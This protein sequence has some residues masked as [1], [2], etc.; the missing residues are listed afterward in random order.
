MRRSS[1]EGKR[2]AGQESWSRLFSRANV[3]PDLPLH[4]CAAEIREAMQRHSV[5]I[6][7]GETGSGKTT[8]VPKCALHAGLGKEGKI[9]LTQPRRLAAVR[10]A[11]RIAE[12]CGVELG[13]EIGYRIRFNAK[14]SASVCLEVV[15][16][17]IPVGGDLRRSPFRECSAVIVDEVHERSVNMDVILGLLKKER[18]IRP[19]LRIV[20]MSATLQT[21]TF[22]EFFPDA[23]L[24]RVPGRTYPVEMIYDPPRDEDAPLA[25]LMAD[26]VRRHVADSGAGNTLCFLPTERSI[27]E[28]AGLLTGSFGLGRKINVF[29]LYSR[30]A[31]HEQQRVF[32]QGGPRR[33]ILAT[34]IAETSLTLPGVTRVIDSGWVRMLRYQPTRRVSRLHLEMISKASANQR[35]GRAGRTAPGTCVRLYSRDTFD[36]MED[37][38]TP[39][40]RRIDL[41]GVLLKLIDHGMSHPEVFPFP[42]APKEKMFREGFGLLELL[43]LIQEEGF[44]YRSTREGRQV[45]ALPLSPRLGHFLY[46]SRLEG[47]GDAAA[48]LAAYLSIQ[49]PKVTPTGEEDAARKAHRAWQSESSDFAGIVKIYAKWKKLCREETGKK[50]REWTKKQYLSLRRMNEWVQLADELAGVEAYAGGD[51]KLD[52]GHLHSLILGSHLDMLAE[53]DTEKKLYRSPDSGEIFVHPASSLKDNPPKWAVAAEL[54]DTGRLYLLSGAGIE[55]EWLLERARDNLEFKRRQPYYDEKTRRVVS[56]EE[57]FLRGRLVMTRTRRD[58]FAVDPEQATAV[59]FRE[60]ILDQ[61]LESREAGELRSAIDILHNMDAAARQPGRFF[62]DIRVIRVLRER[63]GLCSSGDTLAK[64][65]YVCPSIEDMLESEERDE[66][67]TRFPCMVKVGDASFEIRYRM[68]VKGRGDGACLVVGG[69][70]ALLLSPGD[71]DRAVPGYL[72]KRMGA[73]FDALSSRVRR[74]LD[75]EQCVA[76]WLDEYQQ[77]WG[78]EDFVE[79]WCNRNLGGEWDGRTFRN[80]LAKACPDYLIPWIDTG[81]GPVRF[82]R[83]LRRE[84]IR[85]ELPKL[86]KGDAL[87]EVDFRDIRSLLDAAETA[88]EEVVIESV[89]GEPY[90]V[91]SGLQWVGDGIV[92][93]FFLDGKTATRETGIA[94]GNFATR[95]EAFRF[96]LSEDSR[97][98]LKTLGIDAADYSRE[99][100]SA[101][102]REAW[103][104]LGKTDVRRSVGEFRE[105]LAEMEARSLRE[106]APGLFSVAVRV[107]SAGNRIRLV[108]ASSSPAAKSIDRLCVRWTGG[109]RPRPQ[110]ILREGTDRFLAKLGILEIL[111]EAFLGSRSEFDK[112]FSMFERAR[113]TLDKLSEIEF[114]RAAEELN[115]FWGKLLVSPAGKD[116]LNDLAN[117]MLENLRSAEQSINSFREEFGDCERLFFGWLR[118]RHEP[119]EGS[120][121]LPKGLELAESSFTPRYRR[122]ESCLEFVRWVRSN[123]RAGTRR[124]AKAGKVEERVSKGKVAES[125]ATA[126]KAGRR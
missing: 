38:T 58:H 46:H 19:D 124:A 16:D 26:A 32:R 47:A 69:G 51:F 98:A 12:E 13:I 92:R 83:N 40:I 20:L 122:V 36:S 99:V 41:A 119:G 55:P 73:C 23:R 113:I 91:W 87:K 111:S 86:L 75:R 100:K 33:V 43:G 101:C 3:N 105:R 7:A 116:N 123:D 8:Q 74:E 34:N 85:E 28:C 27:K 71:L 96:K 4:G 97:N 59:F 90:S 81:E 106:L 53:Y 95:N 37:Y 77:P 78:L 49:D 62:N 118:A 126:W 48:V 120:A 39:E 65:N 31:Q 60:A 21:D 117:R 112:A 44:G 11:E 89:F 82:D 94:V 125:L 66:F 63:V 24:I 70:D 68:R 79:E 88:G 15:T 30:M 25:E 84:L 76:A 80:Q 42:E 52:E 17:G 67:L 121:G 103:S 115:D 18:E 9:L 5:V 6:I 1:G 45:A 72:E 108:R 10:T 22:T 35:A 2:Y 14:T 54:L 110:E 104:R 64:A 57:I 102:Q 29:P 56:D 114:C 109:M 93:R 50:R 61:W 107:A